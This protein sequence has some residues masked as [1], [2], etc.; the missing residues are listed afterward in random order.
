MS[1]QVELLMQLG[2]EFLKV[3]CVV[4]GTVYIPQLL[5][6]HVPLTCPLCC[7]FQ[8]FVLI[9]IQTGFLTECFFNRCIKS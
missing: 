7:K 6:T 4:V 3:L 5:T 8:T 2:S 1:D 9:N